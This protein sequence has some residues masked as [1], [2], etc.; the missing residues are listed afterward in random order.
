VAG[1]KERDPLQKGFSEVFWQKRAGFS[2]LFQA[3]SH[4]RPGVLRTFSSKSMMTGKTT[5]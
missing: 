2:L 4:F 1:K 3:K 5:T